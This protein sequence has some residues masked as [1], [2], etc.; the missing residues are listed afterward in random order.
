MSVVFAMLPEAATAKGR[1]KKTVLVAHDDGLSDNYDACRI[2][3]CLLDA[4]VSDGTKSRQRDPGARLSP[5]LRLSGALCFPGATSRVQDAISSYQIHSDRPA[6][7]SYPI[8]S[9]SSPPPRSPL[10]PLA[11]L[12]LPPF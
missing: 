3:L 6:L 11:E 8:P 12:L 1:K 10:P 2:F 5:S 7:T 9:L 4:G